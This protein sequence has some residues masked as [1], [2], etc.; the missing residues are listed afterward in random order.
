MSYDDENIKYISIPEAVEW[1]A[2][3]GVIITRPTAISWVRTHKLGH[4]PGGTNYSPSGRK[5]SHWMVDKRRW[6][7]FVMGTRL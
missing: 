2:D 4:Q 5:W 1:A 6:E 7:D 3:Q